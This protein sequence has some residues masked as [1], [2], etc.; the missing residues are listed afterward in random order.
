[1]DR[2][3]LIVQHGMDAIR[4]YVAFAGPIILITMAALATW[5]FTRAGG[6]IAWSTDRPL[7]GAA[8][9]RQIFAGGAL[10][11]SIYATSY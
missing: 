3:D 4:R 11:V 1:M 9:W 7:T 8:M 2:A 10:W 6:S 5:I